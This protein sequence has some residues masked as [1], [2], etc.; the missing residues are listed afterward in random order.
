MRR[1]VLK[2]ILLALVGVVGPL[3]LVVLAVPLLVDANR[4]KPQLEAAASDTLGMDVRIGRLS[5]G[6]FPALHLAM[7]DAR[8][9]GEHGEAVASAKRTSLGIDLLPLLRKHAS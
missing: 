6:F 8:V 9:L 3:V 5:M 4:Y 2:R 1:H 7:E